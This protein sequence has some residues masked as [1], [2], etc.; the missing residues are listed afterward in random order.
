MSLLPAFSKILE[1]IM[2]NKIMSFFDSKN[3]FYKHQYGFRSK[4]ATIHPILHLLNICAKSNNCQPK[5]LTASILCDLSKA[6]DV[7]SHD[8]LIRKLEYYGIRGVVKNWL[9][10]YLT[11]RHQYVEFENSKSDKCKIECGVPQG[12]ILGPLLYLIY[13]NDIAQCTESHILSFADDTTLVISEANPQ[14]LFQRVNV[15]VDHL[16]N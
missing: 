16:Y 8:I 9:I 12:S 15:E 5:L 6:F 13:V 11:D 4:H 1:K 10:N 3:M 7:I 14:L 2:F